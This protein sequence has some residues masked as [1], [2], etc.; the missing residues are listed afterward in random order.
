MRLLNTETLLFSEFFEPNV[1]L[2][3]ILS[4]CW[5]ED[6]VTHQDV[7]D[8]QNRHKAGWNKVTKSSALA[9]RRGFEFIWIDTCCIDKSSSAEL[10]GPLIRCLLVSKCG[11]MLRVSAQCLDV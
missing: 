4:H 5:E 11:Q 8:Q 1:P 3:A 2:Y 10:S 7:R 9:L 6:E